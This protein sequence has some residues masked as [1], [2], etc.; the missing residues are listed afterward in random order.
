MR[1]KERK[2]REQSNKLTHNWFLVRCKRGWKVSGE[3]TAQEVKQW[4]VGVG[5]I[6]REA[7]PLEEQETLG[8]GRTPCLSNQAR[9]PDPRF[10]TNESSLPLPAPG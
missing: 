2:I 1:E 5:G 3:K 6:R 10:A 7:I 8:K 9:F 4:G